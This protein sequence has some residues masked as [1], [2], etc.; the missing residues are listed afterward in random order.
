MCVIG[1]ASCAQFCFDAGGEFAV[2]LALAGPILF[3]DAASHLLSGASSRKAPVSFS[4]FEGEGVDKVS[5]PNCFEL[6]FHLG[7]AH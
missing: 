6:I 5:P 4:A 3:D 2:G 1:L 7:A